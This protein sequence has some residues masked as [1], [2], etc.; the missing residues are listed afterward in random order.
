[1]GHR[2]CHCHSVAVP[3]CCRCTDRQGRCDAE[4]R[5]RFQATRRQ[6]FA[7]DQHTK[8]IDSEYRY[9]RNEHLEYFCEG[10]KFAEKSATDLKTVRWVVGCDLRSILFKDN[11]L[12]ESISGE[13]C[14]YDDLSFVFRR[15]AG[16]KAQDGQILGRVRIKRSSMDKRAA[17]LREPLEG[18]FDLVK[19]NATPFPNL[20]SQP[21]PE[22]LSSLDSPSAIRDEERRCGEGEALDPQQAA[23]ALKDSTVVVYDQDGRFNGRSAEYFDSNGHIVGFSIPYFASNDKVQPDGLRPSDDSGRIFIHRWTIDKKGYLCRTDPQDPLTFD[24]TYSVRRHKPTPG[25]VDAPPR[26]CL[27]DG[28]VQFIIKGNPFAVD[29]EHLRREH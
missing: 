22:L 5:G 1:M 15:M 25:A 17:T 18:E 16:S 19:G 23:Q 12:C 13:G 7:L 3:G 9:F 21:K 10:G 20:D 27:Y 26:L 6:H 14:Q 2:F 29:V 24:C 28:Y 11:H 4:G 8:G